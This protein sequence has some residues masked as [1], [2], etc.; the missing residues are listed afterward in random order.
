MTRYDIA[1]FIDLD[2]YL[3][4]HGKSIEEHVWETG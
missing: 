4:L 1:L 2:E 3:V